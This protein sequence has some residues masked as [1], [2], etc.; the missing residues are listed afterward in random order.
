MNWCAAVTIIGQA[1]ETHTH[2]HT[3]RASESESESAC[4]RA[5]VKRKFTA[6]GTKDEKKKLEKEAESAL[7][8]LMRLLPLSLCVVAATRVRPAAV[9]PQHLRVQSN[10]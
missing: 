2:T 6:A 3:D 1:C 9:N 4:E 8:G 10:E 5:V 7:E